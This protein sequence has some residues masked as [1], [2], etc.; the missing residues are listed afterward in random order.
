M[1]TPQ[2]DDICENDNGYFIGSII[3]IDN[4]S[5]AFQ[6]KELEVVDGQQRLTTL[7][8]LLT[9]IYNRLKIHKDELDEDDEDE[10]PAL[11]KSIICK[12]ASNGLILCP[13][14]QNHNQADFNVVMYENGLLKSAKREKNWGNRKIAKC[15][16]Y[17][18]QRLDQDI[19]ESGDAVKTLLEIKSKV[20]KQ[21]QN[22]TAT[23][24]LPMK[25]LSITQTAERWGIST[26]RIQI[27]CGEGR[28]PGAI[29]IGTVWGIPEDAEKPADARI[30]N[31]RYIKKPVEN[32]K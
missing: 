6:T 15:Y 10:L 29:R 5:D 4:S 1:P 18:L 23:G 32:E 24:V 3:C 27:L 7:C 22:E 16:K 8:L 20:S 28:V 21:T 11:R 17:F 13:Q 2:Y 26:R 30:K 12:G 31:G 19:E 9:A 14:I 25:Y